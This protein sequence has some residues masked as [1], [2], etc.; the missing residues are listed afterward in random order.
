MEFLGTDAT[1]TTE[2]IEFDPHQPP[3]HWDQGPFLPEPLIGP[4]LVNINEQETAVIGGSAGGQAK[5]SIHVYNWHSK[6]WRMGPG[7]NLAR[8]AHACVKIKNPVGDRWTVI[9]SGT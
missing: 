6:L 4:C 8:S 3:T 2:I 1:D 5:T 9:I 7:L